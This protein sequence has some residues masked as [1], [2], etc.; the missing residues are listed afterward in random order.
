MINNRKYT[1]N[2][3]SDDYIFE[4]EQEFEKQTETPDIEEIAVTLDGGGAPEGDDGRTEPGQNAQ[5]EYA[6][7]YDE[8]EPQKPG[9]RGKI[10]AVAGAV[11]LVVAALLAAGI[12][13]HKFTPSKTRVNYE[14]YFGAAG[15]TPV[16]IYNYVKS[17]YKVKLEDG[18][19]YVENKFL[20]DNFT[21]K[22]FY[23][24]G[25]NEVLYTTAT[26]IYT[27][28]VG[29]KN[30]SVDGESRQTDKQ[31]V[32]R[33]NDTLYILLEF[34]SERCD[35]VW[36]A[37]EA[38][39][40]LVIVDGGSEYMKTV[41]NEEY[42]VR[43][44]ASIK[45]SIMEDTS[46][47]ADT[48]WMLEEGV[49]QEQEWLKVKSED[50]RT[51]YVKSS[52]TTGAAVRYTYDS[53]YKKE[54]YPSQLRNHD[55]LLVW[56]AVYD[57]ND[58]AK[59]E[60]LLAD[61][62]GVN[63]VSPTWYKAVDAKGNIQSMAD[64]AY[65]EYI[66]GLGMEIWPLISDF[67][68]AEGD[69]WDEKELLCN[70]DSRR[71]LIENIMAEIKDYGYDGINVDFEKVSQ[72]A[73]DGYI[74]FIRELSISC[75]KAG[76]VLSVD[77]YVPKPYNMQ[78]NR[79]GQGECADYVIVMGYDEHYSGGSEAGSVASIGFV[80]E[81]ISES[82]KEVPREKLINAVPFYTRLWIEGPDGEGNISLSSK[83]YGMGGG[84]QIAEELGLT[85][86]WDDEVKQFV[87]TGSADG[88]SYSIWLEDERSMEERIK[89]IR[90]YNIAGVAAW[91][92]GMESDSVWDI[93][94][95]K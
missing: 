37:Y 53:E 42:V 68:S 60:E 29:E 90:S 23:D 40:R 14:E 34:A 24:E 7:L 82:L 83:S 69:G 13:I 16:L 35:M 54:E 12:I 18:A 19:F 86:I 44:S 84:A 92:L 75:R 89:L 80:N 81:G 91:C 10:I 58:N 30:Y 43:D 72:E 74:Q 71:R 59:I 17:D 93:I 94:A 27:F 45:G 85:K 33:E 47:N 1:N 31:V 70:T 6:E 51:G 11:L 28:P 61:S 77:N 87:A 26:Q 38:P 22:F 25:R 56:H 32:L 46:D 3:D 67:T 4:D 78:Y 52:H 73:G 20:K 15:K 79:A 65:V 9:K 95:G 48:M 36:R 63:T 64:R 41:L 57:L 2:Q 55:I 88:K 62:K 66:H 8:E 49:S 50:G 76:V 39:D 21:D 5:E